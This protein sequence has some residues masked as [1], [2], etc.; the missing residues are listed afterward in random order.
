MECVEQ[1]FC[2]DVVVEEDGSSRT[3][4]VADGTAPIFDTTGEEPEFSNRFILERL[5]SF[6]KTMQTRMIVAKATQDLPLLFE[7]SLNGS[8]EGDSYVKFMIAPS[9]E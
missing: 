7:H 4:A 9:V 6:L 2:H 5:E 1:K 8:T 3:R